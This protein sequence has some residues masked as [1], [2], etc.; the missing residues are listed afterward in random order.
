MAGVRLELDLRMPGPQR[1]RLLLQGLPDLS[2]ALA[3]V[4]EHARSLALDAFDAG[5]S[6]GGAAWLPS[7]RA[8]AEGGLTLVDTATLRNELD[9]QA[10]AREVA[11]GS[12]LEYAAIHQLGGEAGP[13]QR[14]VTLPARPYLPSAEELDQD[15]VATLLREALEGAL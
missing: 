13:R 14:R 2:E 9:V 10:S 3:A 1:A 8:L 4:G 5:R 6:P 11:V 12:G 15:Y 7:Q